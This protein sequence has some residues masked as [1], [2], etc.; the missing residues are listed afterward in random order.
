MTDREGCRCYS[1]KEVKGSG[2]VEALL[3][4]PIVLMFFM[5]FVWLIDL[6]RVHSVIGA[7][8]NE[9]GYELVSFSYPGSL[10]GESDEED[11]R[12]F[13]ALGSIVISEG[14]LRTRVS[15]CD[16][17]D[18][19]SNLS[20]FLSHVGEEEISLSVSYRVEPIIEIP[21]FSGFVLTNSFYSKGYTGFR[22][23]SMEEGYVYVT[24][25]SKVYHTST[26]C[27][28]L[29]RTVEEISIDRIDDMRNS[30]G[31]KYYECARC[32][33]KGKPSVVYITPY[34]NRYHTS[35]ECEDIKVKVYKLPIGEI[36]DRR[37]CYFCE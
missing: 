34:G 12:I 31:S 36:G 20:C 28:A 30:D 8:V 7:T 2:T 6:Y 10:L 37:K 32:K 9:V 14:Y 35:V 11:N 1:Q 15:E 21:G 17:Y 25:G 22:N 16:A 13:E 26:E 3:I 24:R 29:K 18:R 4:F 33:T 5:A 19:I 23:D 27:L